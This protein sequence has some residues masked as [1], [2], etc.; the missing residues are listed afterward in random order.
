VRHALR[1]L[2][3]AGVAAGL[4]T[5]AASVAAM[6]ACGCSS[7][8][9]QANILLR[10]QN[11]QLTSQVSDLQTKNA[12]LEAQINAIQSQPGSTVPQLPESRLDQLFTVHGVEFGKLTGGYSPDPNG[13][14]Q[15]VKVY[16]VPTDDEGEALK[17]AGSFS[18]ELFDLAEQDTRLGKWDFPT[19]KSRQ[20]F[21]GRMFLYTYEFDCPWQ[22]IPRHSKLHLRVTFTD[23]LTGRVF[24]AEEDINVKPPVAATQP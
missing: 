9:S 12:G 6:S 14:D 8:P 1:R 17:S 4:A 5:L 18:I 22:K 19:E 21:Y 23:E 16:V 3:P 20:D 10:K 24:V 11:Q 15:M 2:A 13:P 7:G